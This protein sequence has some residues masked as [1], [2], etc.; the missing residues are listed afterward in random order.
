MEAVSVSLADFMGLVRSPAS[1]QRPGQWAFN[2]L[3]EV[4][5]D[6]AG[7]VR[8]SPVDPFHNDRCLPAFYAWVGKEWDAEP[9]DSRPGWGDVADGAP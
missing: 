2:L 7:R 6:L 3:M 1:S 8:A 9:S 4:R 5:P